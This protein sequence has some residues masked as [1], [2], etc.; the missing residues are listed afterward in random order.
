MKLADFVK[1][2][3][4]GKTSL[5]RVFWLYSVLGSLLFGSIELFLNPEN[6]FIMRS[7]SILGI[8]FTVYTTVAIYRCANNCRS[9]AVARLARV[10]AVATLILLPVLTYF[11][12]TGSLSLAN[13][14][15]GQ[16]P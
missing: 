9:P 13:L 2:P 1:E 5:S 11:D 10:G 15:G 8:F 3:L 14:T 16:L 6:Q 12:L 7:Y 4:E